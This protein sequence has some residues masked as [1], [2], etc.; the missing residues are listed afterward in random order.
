MKSLPFLSLLMLFHTNAMT[1]LQNTICPSKSSSRLI[2]LLQT[3]SD[4]T[5]PSAVLIVYMP[6]AKHFMP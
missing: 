3:T 5:T 6:R 2:C 1:W 4:L